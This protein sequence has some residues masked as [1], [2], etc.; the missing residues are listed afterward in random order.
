MSDYAEPAESYPEPT[1]TVFPPLCR[2]CEDTINTT[3]MT[4]ND[5]AGHAMTFHP[6][7]E[8]SCYRDFRAAPQR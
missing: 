4:V 6:A 1:R 2:W 8:R 5:D 3:P 7:D